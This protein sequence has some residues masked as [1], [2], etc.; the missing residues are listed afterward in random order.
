[1]L[2][3]EHSDAYYTILI[4]E[5]NR[6]FGVT[7]QYFYDLVGDRDEREIGVNRDNMKQSWN[8]QQG[9]QFPKARYQDG[10]NFAA[11]EKQPINANDVLNM[12]LAVIL[13]TGLFQLKYTEWHALP[14]NEQTIV[15]TW[16]W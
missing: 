3:V 4:T 2:A 6:R 5:T 12:L 10:A 1:M 13:D 8:T 14:D 15:N 7:F 11:F 9:F 16:K